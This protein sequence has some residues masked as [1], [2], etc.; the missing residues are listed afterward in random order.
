MTAVKE[1]HAYLNLDESEVC[2]QC[3]GSGYRRIE[4]SGA[5]AH[6]RCPQCDGTGGINS[7]FK[8]EQR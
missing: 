6:E 4:L 3:L 8:G 1:Q 2:P 7:N 5:S